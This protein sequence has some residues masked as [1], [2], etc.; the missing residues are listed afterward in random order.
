LIA[1]GR[2]DTSE[3]SAYADERAG[4][5]AANSITHGADAA[6]GV[7]DGIAP[8]WITADRNGYFSDAENIEHHEL[9]G[10][11]SRH[12]G[13]IRRGQIQGACIRVLFPVRSN[14]E[15]GRLHWLSGNHFH[16][17][18][19]AAGEPPAGVA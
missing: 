6:H 3:R 1:V 13:S 10:P 15:C 5:R 7:R 11:P 8:L 4:F 19:E 16:K 14:A 12:V 2:P 9:S 18:P 17:D